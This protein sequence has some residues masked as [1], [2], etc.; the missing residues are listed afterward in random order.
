MKKVT[1]LL[2]ALVAIA[3][4]TG[5]TNSTKKHIGKWGDESGKGYFEFRDDGSMALIQNNVI[6]EIVTDEK[7]GLQAKWLY[8]ID[9]N[10]SPIE[11]TW[12]LEGMDE[13]KAKKIVANCLVR[14]KN[15]NEMELMINYKGSKFV[16][17]DVNDKENYA[18][19][20][21]AN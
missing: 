6:T 8:K 15:N 14:F 16:D 18:V 19:L 20:K 1:L 3:I 7:D 5:C 10:K 17:F 11:M 2:T 4:F 13:L 9:Y 12:Y 21:K